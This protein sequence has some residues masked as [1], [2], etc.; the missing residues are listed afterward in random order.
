MGICTSCKKEVSRL[1]G[2]VCVECLSVNA[3]KEEMQKMD[4]EHSLEGIELNTPLGSD[5]MRVLRCG[6]GN[7]NTLKKEN[8]QDKKKNKVA[9]EEKSNKN[10]E[11]K[12]KISIGE[13]FICISYRPSSDV[14]L[15]GT[16]E[17]TKIDGSIYD[18]EDENVWYFNRL[19][20]PEKLRGKG[21]ASILLDELVKVL[22]KEGITLICEVNA[23]GD[24]SEKELK[25][26][27]VRHGFSMTKEGY[28]IYR[29][30]EGII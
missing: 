16:A 30:R 13:D 5:L 10:N 8:T 24:M 1:Y 7:F 26:M 4:E 15:A 12:P 28:L 17:L 25:R 14:P 2:E 19:L 9:T 18:V 22:N 3:G 29:K 27:Y 23:Y 20:V 21:I 6:Q 11:N